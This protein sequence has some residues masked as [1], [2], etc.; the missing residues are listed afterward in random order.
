MSSDVL[1]HRTAKAPGVTTLATYYGRLMSLSRADI[2]GYL[3][4]ESLWPV[5]KAP[6]SREANPGCRG[7]PARPSMSASSD[8]GTKEEEEEDRNSHLP[9]GSQERLLPDTQS[10]LPQGDLP[11]TESNVPQGGDHSLTQRVI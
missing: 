2:P 1:G 6:A 7:L 11:D 8:D 4:V 3:R 10:H 9:Q 5:S